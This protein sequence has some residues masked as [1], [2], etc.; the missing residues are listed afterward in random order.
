MRCRYLAIALLGAGALIARPAHAQCSPG[1]ITVTNTTSTTLSLC[2]QVKDVLLLT[3][4]G[5]SSSLG[6]PKLLN[7]GPLATY[8]TSASP[9]AALASRSI[10]VTANRAYDLSIA[11]AQSTFGPSGVNKPVG[12]I[13]WRVGAGAFA[14]ISTTATSLGLTGTAGTA[15]S[16][17]SFQSRWAFERDVPG[18]YSTTVV[19]TL[20]AR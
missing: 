19:L 9:L 17:I 13:Q 1:A 4:D 2:M 16:T 15:S 5:N 14:P 6:I 10:T 20:S 8:T 18:S 12:D 7:Y 3:V 11:A